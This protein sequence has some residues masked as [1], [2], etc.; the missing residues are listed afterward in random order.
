VSEVAV[1]D[2]G[3]S[4]V[5]KNPI[6]DAFLSGWTPDSTDLVCYRDGGYS[7]VLMDGKHST[8]GRLPGATNVLGTERVSYLPRSGTMPE[9]LVGLP[10]G[11]C[12]LSQ[13]DCDTY[14]KSYR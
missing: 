5:V 14:H 1:I 9:Q 10:L 6:A 13:A 7:L 11:S 2:T 12:H 3:G 8:K 4:L